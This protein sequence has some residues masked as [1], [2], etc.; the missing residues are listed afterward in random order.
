MHL[1]DYLLF[2]SIGFLGCEFV[3]KADSIARVMM[4]VWTYLGG[5]V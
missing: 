2:G 4:E 5:V 1:D 3:D